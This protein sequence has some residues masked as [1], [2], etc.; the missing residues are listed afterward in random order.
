ME[1]YNGAVVVIICCTSIKIPIVTILALA[2]LVAGHPCLVTLAVFFKAAALLAGAALVVLW[3]H[4]RLLYLDLGL[5]ARNF[6]LE[7]SRIFFK[8]VFDSDLPCVLEAQKRGFT[9]CFL[10]FRQFTQLQPLQ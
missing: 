8:G 2:K 7:S 4:R 3:H 1:E 5:A 10:I 6:W 9:S